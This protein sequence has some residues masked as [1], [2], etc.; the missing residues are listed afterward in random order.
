MSW[1]GTF[2]TEGLAYASSSPFCIFEILTNCPNF[3]HVFW[4][5]VLAHVITNILEEISIPNENGEKRPC[6]TVYIFLKL[7]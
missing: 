5:T 3:V 7:L 6:F 2:L 4:L 1:Q